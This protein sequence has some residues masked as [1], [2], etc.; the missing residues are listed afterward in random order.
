MKGQHLRRKPPL[1]MPVQACIFLAA[2]ALFGIG[3]ARLAADAHPDGRASPPPTTT[4]TLI[5]SSVIVPETTTTTTL[6]PTTTDADKRL[7]LVKAPKIRTTVRTTAS[8]QQSTT[9]TTESPKTPLEVALKYLGQTGP[10]AD[11]GFYCAKAVSYFAQEAQVEGFVSRDGPSALY[12]DAVR[13]GR[14]T[15]TR[16]SET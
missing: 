2:F 8:T 9:T 1:P 5:N 7:A 6:K 10:W 13:D 12:A 14:V 15:Q 3:V 4:T 11:G 16:L